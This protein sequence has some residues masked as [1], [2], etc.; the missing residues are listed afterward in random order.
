MKNFHTSVIV[1]AEM[2]RGIGS[3]RGNEPAQPDGLDRWFIRMRTRLGDR[4]LPTDAPGAD[5]WV[6]ASVPDLL[7]LIDGLL[8]A[9]AKVHGLTPVPRN[10]ADVERG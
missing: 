10:I 1:L 8:T 7:P 5:A 3:K 4:V 6:L 2:R 9:T